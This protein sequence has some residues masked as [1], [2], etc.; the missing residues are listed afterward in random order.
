MP[1][2]IRHPERIEFIRQSALADSQFFNREPIT[3]NRERL[4]VL[5]HKKWVHINYH[6]NVPAA[7]SFLVF[8]Q[9]LMNKLMKMFCVWSF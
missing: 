4:P 1:D 7:N 2:L 5:H 3:V 9:Q 6:L 8:K